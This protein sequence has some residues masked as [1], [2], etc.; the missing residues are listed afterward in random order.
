MTCWAVI[1][2]EQAL[3][4]R[5]VADATVGPQDDPPPVGADPPGEQ[6]QQGGLAGA[7]LTDDAGALA[8]RER[9]AHRVEYGPAVEGLADGERG[10]LCRHT[11]N[12]EAVVDEAVAADRRAGESF[13][14]ASTRLL[15]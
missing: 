3:V 14:K 15:H 10:D 11:G 8:L 12:S 6:P 9:A 7:V 1:S 4:L 5:E 2:A 13:G